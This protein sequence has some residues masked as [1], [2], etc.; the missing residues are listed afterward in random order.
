MKG[1]NTEKVLKSIVDFWITHRQSPTFA[2]I[3]SR[4]GMSKSTIHW[5]VHRLVDEGRLHLHGLVPVGISISY[6]D[7]HITS[8]REAQMEADEQKERD[9]YLHETTEVDDGGYQP[10]SDPEELAKRVQDLWKFLKE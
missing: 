7:P 1:E 10:T 5:H 3:A 8:N 6:E 4:V 9:W 2:M